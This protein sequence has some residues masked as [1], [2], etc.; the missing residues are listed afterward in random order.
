[1]NQAKQPAD[2]VVETRMMKALSHPL[3][4]RILEHL[5][6]GPASPSMIATELGEPLG[7]V[8]YHVKI[9]LSYDAIELV[10]TR[11]V[12]G[13]LEHVYR[14]IERPLTRLVETARAGGN[15]GTT[16]VT[17]TRLELDRKAHDELTE[18]LDQVLDRAKELEADAARRTAEAQGDAAEHHRTELAIFYF[19]RAAGAD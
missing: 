15:D 2:T 14:A 19:H 12:R 1:M 10:E 13:A 16:Q 7:N 18:L 9:L 3:R 4:W 11:P 6:A 8:S 5:A 17:S